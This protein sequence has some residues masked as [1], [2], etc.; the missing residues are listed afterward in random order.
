MEK[1]KIRH[2]FPGGNTPQGFFSYYN[3]II[4]ND[5][6]RIFILKGG[7]GTGKSTFM[8]KIGEELVA[9]GY[10]AEFHH[11]SSDNNSLDGVVI[12]K[13]KV[14]LIDGTAPH[15]VDPKLPGCID[16][17][18]PLGEYWDE[19]GIL[20]HKANIMACTAEISK[21]YQRA[22]R[23]LRAAKY[24]YE[25]FAAINTEALDILKTNQVAHDLIEKIFND[26]KKSGSGKI[27]KLFASAITPDGP[28]NYLES[29]VWSVGT[30]HVISGDPGTGKSTIIQKVINT[31]VTMGFAIEVYYCPLDPEK[32]EHVVIPE[33]NT[34]VTTSNIPHI[35]SPPKGNLFTSVNM[36]DYLNSSITG[37]YQENIS[38]DQQMFWELF[39]K[40]IGCLKQSKQLHDQL[41]NYYVP[42]MNFQGINDLR[43]KTMKRILSYQN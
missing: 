26:S 1:A 34:G 4:S 16:E 33:L 40:T 42:Y 31:A 39:G 19:Q 14:A 32:P 29:S 12:P 15:V 5:A 41:E 13:L 2:L 18:L 20:A 38:Y 9:Q 30:C 17:I 27:R 23:L 8:R 10:D 35:Y 7:P 21:N 6:N 25:D 43:E 37:K 22:Y 36:N 24:I 28:V 3:Y 11:C